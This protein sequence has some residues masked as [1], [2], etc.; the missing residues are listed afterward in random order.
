VKLGANGTQLG[1]DFDLAIELFFLG[2]TRFQLGH[3]RL[4]RPGEQCAWRED[5]QTSSL[6]RSATCANALSRLT[7]VTSTATAWAAIIMSKSLRLM[8]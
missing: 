5:Y 2:E 1:V 4:G 6:K 3:C 8:P 7:R